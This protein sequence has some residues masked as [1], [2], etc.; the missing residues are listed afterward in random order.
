M[1]LLLGFFRRQSWKIKI[2]RNGELILIS[3]IQIKLN[4]LKTW[5][6]LT[7]YI[8]VAPPLSHSEQNTA[9]Q[10]FSVTYNTYK[11]IS[12]FLQCYR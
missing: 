11:I 3:P 8:A 6:F 7:F 5:F 1:L 10:Q 9:F 2:L 4:F 12:E